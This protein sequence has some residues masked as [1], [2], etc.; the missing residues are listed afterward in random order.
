MRHAD[1]QTRW[2]A[3][4]C[5]RVVVDVEGIRS[6]G[7]IV[8]SDVADID[9]TSQRQVIGVAQLP[10]LACGSGPFRQR[11]DL[12]PVG[13]ASLAVVGAALRRAHYVPGTCETDV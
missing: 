6:V 9:Q 11:A 1:G 5:N 3:A 8:D 10:L 4:G 2:L 7:V 12:G 13:R